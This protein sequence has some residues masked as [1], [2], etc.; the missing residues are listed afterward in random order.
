VPWLS[1]SNFTLQNGSNRLHSKVDLIDTLVVNPGE[2][3][4]I[5]G[6]EYTICLNDY[7]TDFSNSTSISL[8]F[9]ENTNL[10][11]RSNKTESHLLVCKLDTSVGPFSDLNLVDQC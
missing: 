1:G 10:P 3:L 4:Y 6:N 7:E 5:D 8:C 11:I 2:Y 9:T